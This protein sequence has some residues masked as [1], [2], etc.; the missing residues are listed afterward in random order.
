MDTTNSSENQQRRVEDRKP[1]ET[2]NWE[3]PGAP[4]VPLMAAPVAAER[5]GLPIRYVASLLV[6]SEGASVFTTPDAAR[7]PHGHYMLTAGHH[8]A[9][10]DY[11]Q[12]AGSCKAR[13]ILPCSRESFEAN[14]AATSGDDPADDQW[15]FDLAAEYESR[16]NGL[17]GPVTFTAQQ[18]PNFVKAVVARIE[19][20]AAP[21]PTSIPDVLFDGSAVYDEIVRVKGHRDH[22]VVSDTL[23]AVVRLMRKEGAAAPATASGDELHHNFYTHKAA[24]RSAIEFALEE[25]PTI[26]LGDDDLH[27]YWSHELKAYDDAFGSLPARAAVSAAT[28]PTADLSKLTRYEWT[29]DGMDNSMDEPARWTEPT[30]VK[31]ADVQSLLATKPAAAA[32]AV[33]EGFVLMPEDATAAMIVAIEREV[34]AQLNASGI[35]PPD[36]VRLDGGDIF[37]ALLDAIPATPAASTTGAAQTAEQ[38]RDQALEEA[39]ELVKGCDERAT[40]RG[41]ACAIRA[42]KRPTPTH[43]SEAGDA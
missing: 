6:N 26:G 10:D 30:W 17:C 41:I 40:L 14:R 24:W 15:M 11:S 8:G 29:R 13:G 34:D 33:P 7:L 36:M 31:L 38:V 37:D 28:K 20:A 4:A 5:A 42:L 3:A 19:S 43:S 27:S 18:L 23:D 22:Y 25:A 32:L 39:A 2:I 9:S 35:S 1:S 16:G 21:A 12:Y